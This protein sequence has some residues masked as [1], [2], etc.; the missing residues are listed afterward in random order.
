MVTLFNTGLWGGQDR[1]CLCPLW[2]KQ[3]AAPVPT[4][5]IFGENGLYG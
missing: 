5:S 4:S 2:L 1:R 3:D